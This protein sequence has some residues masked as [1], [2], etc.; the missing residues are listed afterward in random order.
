[1]K[2]NNVGGLFSNLLHKFGWTNPW[3]LMSGPTSLSKTWEYNIGLDKNMDKTYHC[4]LA[5]KHYWAAVSIGL[6]WVCTIGY[7]LC[8][9]LTEVRR[10]A[11]KANGFIL[12]IG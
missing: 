5:H 12:S 8:T 10:V 7:R 9:L 6:A 3:K 1:M 4:A 11:K 2:N